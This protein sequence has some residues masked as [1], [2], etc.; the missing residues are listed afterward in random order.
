MRKRVT[1]SKASWA[2]DGHVE[3]IFAEKPL[4]GKCFLMLLHVLAMVY[5]GIIVIEDIEELM[6]SVFSFQLLDETK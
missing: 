1:A 3:L 5:H 2:A 6:T 4:I